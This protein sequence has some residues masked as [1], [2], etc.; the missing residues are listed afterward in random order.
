MFANLCF[1]ALF[2]LFSLGINAAGFSFCLRPLGNTRGGVRTSSI[3]IESSPTANNELSRTLFLS[4][5]LRFASAL[6]I[7]SRPSPAFAGDDSSLKGTKT[8]PKFQACLSLCM[9]ECTKPKGSEQRSRSECLPEC[10]QKCATTKQQ[11][12]LGTPKE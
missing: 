11:L 10:K 7:A 8:D 9:Y 3:I 5:A 1:K 6:V 2:V 12:L 4:D